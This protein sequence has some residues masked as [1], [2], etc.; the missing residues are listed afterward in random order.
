[1][2]GPKYSR[3][4][5]EHH[6]ALEL[7]KKAQ[8]MLDNEKKKELLAK[9]AELNRQLSSMQ[10]DAHCV[11]FARHIEKAE[12]M[13]IYSADV[14]RL[15]GLNNELSASHEL[16]PSMSMSIDELSRLA[17]KIGKTILSSRRMLAVA[18][19]TDE[20]ICTQY[21]VL[22][23]KKKEADFESTDWSA[24]KKLEYRKLPN[25]LEDEYQRAII[26]AL[27][28]VNPSKNVDTLDRILLDERTDTEYKI[29]EIQLRR[30]AMTAETDAEEHE[31]LI[32]LQSEFV[33]LMRLLG[34]E[35][36]ELPL[37]AAAFRAAIVQLKKE[38]EEHTMAEYVNDALGKV[39]NELGYTIVGS[40]IVYAKNRTINK[41]TYNFSSSSMI[42]SAQ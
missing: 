20:R 36:P 31:E 25:A 26:T 7:L 11:K 16:V 5:I 22:D 15:R 27:S 32:G 24:V 30:R 42:V 1:M 21:A 19:T 28:S 18:Q 23:H 8:I 35:G 33:A 41:S 38:Y 12:A 37:D 2:S 9:I 39:M 14:M 34:K 13:E 3:A 17:Q 29:A 40:D 10:L 4:L 6:R